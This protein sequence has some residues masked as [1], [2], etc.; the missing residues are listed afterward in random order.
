MLRTTCVALAVVMVACT[1]PPEEDV[2]RPT[3]TRVPSAA[4]T[5][6][7]PVTTASGL[8]YVDLR[9]GRD[10]KAEVGK[11]A[12]IHHTCALPD[13]IKIDGS[14]ERGRAL[15]FRVGDGTVV[16]G[17]E[18]GVVGMQVGGIRKLT[19]PPAL[20]YGAEGYEDLVPPNAT[21]SCEIQLL[22]V[23]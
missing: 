16:K 5:V 11:V 13:G 21:L 3:A 9:V 12:V 19:I 7:G 17:W 15:Q 2:R 22:A 8:T 10:A 6:A 23:Q 20:G 18:E 1:R 14:R 4:V